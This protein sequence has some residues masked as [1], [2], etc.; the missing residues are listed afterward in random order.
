MRTFNFSSAVVAGILPRSWAA[1]V[2]ALITLLCATPAAVAASGSTISVGLTH[3]CALKDDGTVRCWGGN[4]QGQLGSAT[5]TLR[6][7]PWP[8]IVKRAAGSGALTSVSAVVAGSSHSCALISDGTVACWGDNSS[9]QL[10]DHSMPSSHIPVVV[11]DAGGAGLLRN[12]TAVSA[13]GHS[14]CAVIKGGSAKCWGRGVEGQLGHGSFNNSPYP[15]TVSG[16][17]SSV[18]ALDVGAAHACA[19]LA[20]GTA[21]CWGQGLYGQLGNGSWI[22]G[23]PVPTTVRNETNTQ[24]LTAIVAITTGDAHTCALRVDMTAMCWGNNEFAQLG[25]RL[26]SRNLP[27]KLSGVA[28]AVSLNAGFKQTLAIKA[29]G[30]ARWW[31]SGGAVRAGKNATTLTPIQVSPVVVKDG[32]N[33]GTLSAV[34]AVSPGPT[35]ACA[36]RSAGTVACWGDNRDGQLGDGT[37]AMR[38]APVTVKSE[39]KTAKLERMGLP[40][41]INSAMDG[42]VTSQWEKANHAN[43]GVFNTT[44][45]PQNVTFQKSEMGLTLKQCFTGCLPTLSAKTYESGEYRAR[46][47]TGYGKYSARMKPAK[48]SGVVSSMFVYEPNL[49]PQGQPMY[50][51]QDEIDIEILGRTDSYVKADGNPGGSCNGRMML[52]VN[53]YNNGAGGN[54]VRIPLSFDASNGYHTYTFDWQPN[55]IRWTVDGQVVWTYWQD[56]A[57]AVRGWG[58]AGFDSNCKAITSRNGTVRLPDL[59]GRTMLNFWTGISLK[60]IVGWLGIF[61]YS[62]PLVTSYD[63]ITVSRAAAQ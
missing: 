63:W 46:A 17:T 62:R 34:V 52:Q 7:R 37:T 15:V 51:K 2:V 56:S 18:V 41:V 29:D 3:A 50:D 53:Y 42:D 11:K 1:P 54:E 21:K 58:P 32:A 55:Y 13:G 33:K 59:P 26:P 35:H 22:G 5:P 12:V 43:G 36:A 10:G 19:A 20:D 8:D 24:P 49:N 9:G 4:A 31:G 44:W 39:T 38:V 60:D 45:K 14:T 27:Q 57:G 40:L 48:A 25:N 23:Q 61:S 28:G 47:K 30:T 16:L 6:Y